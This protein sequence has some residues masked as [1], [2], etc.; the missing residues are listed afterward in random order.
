MLASA[1]IPRPGSRRGSGSRD[2]ATGGLR[3]RRR[4][5]QTGYARQCRQPRHDH[6]LRDHDHR[7]D[8]QRHAQRHEHAEHPTFDK[9]PPGVIGIAAASWLTTKPTSTTVT[10]TDSA[11]ATNTNPS[12]ARSDSHFTLDQHTTPANGPARGGLLVTPPKLANHCSQRLPSRGW[13][14]LTARITRPPKR[15]CQPLNRHGT[16]RGTTARHRLPERERRH[17]H[18]QCLADTQVAAERRRTA[19]LY[20]TQRHHSRRCG[21][22]RRDQSTGGSV[23]QRRGGLADPDQGQRHGVQ[24]DDGH[25]DGSNPRRRRLVGSRGF[26]LRSLPCPVVP[27]DPRTPPVTDEV[28][29]DSTR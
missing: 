6:P 5:Q 21:H 19:A 14:R 1:T 11:N 23:G 22:Q 15:G 16:G 7:G 17:R 8:R 24:R 12:A 18:V 28:V 2:R 13:R 26:T 27:R 10:V 9:P 20:Q 29:S 25:H 4:P 3:P